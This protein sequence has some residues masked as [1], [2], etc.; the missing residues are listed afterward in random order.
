MLALFNVF[1]VQALSKSASPFFGEKDM[2]IDAREAKALVT[3]V[4]SL[5][6][7]L[8]KTFDS[9]PSEIDQTVKDAKLTLL[10]VNIKNEKSKKFS[11]FFR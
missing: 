9:L 4:E 1:E 11:K 3:V 8:D 5:L 6:D 7:S 10:N 2:T